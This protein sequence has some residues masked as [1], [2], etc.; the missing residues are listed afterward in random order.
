MSCQSS[1]KAVGKKNEIIKCIK[2]KS[3]GIWGTTEGK[4]LKEQRENK[5]TNK[6][7]L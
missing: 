4:Y 2:D 5:K 7:H 1:R 6:K 3:R